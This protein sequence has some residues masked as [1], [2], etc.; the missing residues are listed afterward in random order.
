MLS[1]RQLAMRNTGIG[2]SEMAAVCGESPFETAHDVW[3]R[4]VLG[5]TVEP[6]NAMKFG[7]HVEDAIAS[8]YAEETGAK[9]LRSRTRRHPTEKWMFAT[10]DRIRMDGDRATL[11]E[12]KSVGPRTQDDWGDH[13]EAIPDYY[14]IQCEWTMEVTGLT[15]CDIGALFLADRDFRIYH[16]TKN[17]TLTALAMDIGRTFW[18]QNVV[19]QVEPPIGASDAT[20]AYLAAKYPR[21]TRALIEAP[22]GAEDL[23]L[24]Y[25]AASADLKAA[26]ARRDAA[27]IQLCAMIGDAEG[28]SG[29]WGR[30]TWLN[31]EKGRT[32]WKSVAE[33]LGATA[34]LADQ[35]RGE[36]SRRFLCRMKKEK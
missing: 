34:E 27:K 4:K 13:P 29:P 20:K 22:E 24:A 12:L 15:E 14:R 26:E 3:R 28:I 2:A 35:H 16:I 25:N 1:E 17:Q 33:A 18:H 8:W 6:N 9:L 21:H 11:L 5:E 36:P 10:P 23:V 30:V 31:D 32:N 7:S 19:Q